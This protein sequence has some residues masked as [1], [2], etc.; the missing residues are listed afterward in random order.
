MGSSVNLSKRLS[1]Y[2]NYNYLV[3][4]KRNMLIHKALL[5][6]G[7]SNFK[8]EILEYCDSSVIIQREQYCLDLLNPEYNILRQAGSSF[9]HTHTK[10]TLTK[11]KG[12][13][14][15]PEQL[16]KLRAHLSVLNSREMPK[17]IRAKISAGMA[18]FNVTTKSKPVLVTNITTQV[19]TEDVSI[20]EAARCLNAPKATL[21]R[22]VKK[23][24]LYL[25]IYLIVSKPVS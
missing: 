16:S 2:Y 3:D 6:Y 23:Q 22:Y 10:E 13:V 8:L 15:R 1:N 21:L 4:P 12:R 17:E 25:G 14:M 7:Y 20:S 11:M 24:A 18:N 5:K 9:G 19:T